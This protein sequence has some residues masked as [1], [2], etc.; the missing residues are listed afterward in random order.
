MLPTHA[1]RESGL[2][3]VWTANWDDLCEFQIF[4]VVDS[5]AAAAGSTPRGRRPTRATTELS[6]IT[7]MPPTAGSRRGDLTVQRFAG[8]WS[9]SRRIAGQRSR[10]FASGEIALGQLR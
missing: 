10:S 5:A 8:G 7:K 3:D 1:H 2:L 4:P 9:E 6:T